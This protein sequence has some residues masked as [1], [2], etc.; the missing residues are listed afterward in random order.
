[1][2]SKKTVE[3]WC[4]NQ[5]VASIM[6]NWSHI[7]KGHVKDASGK[8]PAGK[9]YFTGDCMTIVSQI[10]NTISSRLKR[11][12][13]QAGSSSKAIVVR[14]FAPTVVGKD[15]NAGNDCTHV[16]VVLGLATSGKDNGKP[17]IYTSYPGG[18]SYIQGL[19]PL[20]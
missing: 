7:T 20:G 5:K 19:S 2:A 12:L 6:A 4:E 9:S 14:D 15:G 17:I 13:Y 16:V 18:N 11:V 8:A 3:D 10:N 1:M